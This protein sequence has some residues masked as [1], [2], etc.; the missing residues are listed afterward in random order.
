MCCEQA[1]PHTLELDS[2]QL[3]FFLC[4]SAAHQQVLNVIFQHNDDEEPPKHHSLCYDVS[5]SHMRQVHA[6]E[7]IGNCQSQCGPAKC[8]V[9]EIPGAPQ[10]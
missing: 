7:N 6:Y 2:P 9:G 4:W 1:L 3:S 8:P 5:V 10:L